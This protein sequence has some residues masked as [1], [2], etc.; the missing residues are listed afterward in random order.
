MGGDGLCLT[1]FSPKRTEALI[2]LIVNRLR[3]MLFFME[4]VQKH[5][6][7]TVCVICSIFV[8]AVLRF[9][10]DL[11]TLQTHSGWVRDLRRLE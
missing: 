8:I 6:A 4:I 9:T 11:E 10:L 2:R 3:I 7:G 5:E 1:G